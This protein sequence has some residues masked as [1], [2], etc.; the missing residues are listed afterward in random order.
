MSEKCTLIFGGRFQPF[1]LGHVEVIRYLSDNFEGN[2]ILGIVNPDPEQSVPGDDKDWVRFSKEKNPLSYWER[3]NLIYLSLKEFNLLDK[4]EAIVPLPRP[5]INLARAENYLS[6]KPRKFVLCKKWNDEVEIW[7]AEKYIQNGEEVLWVPFDA[8]S[9]LTKLANGELIRSLMTLGNLGWK[10]FFP[11]S[12]KAFIEDNNLVQKIIVNNT[13][14]QAKEY[15]L[16]ALKNE[17]LS[18]YLIEIVT[19]F[20]INFSNSEKIIHTKNPLEAGLRYFSEFGNILDHNGFTIEDLLSYFKQTNS[21]TG[22]SKISEDTHLR[23]S[24]TTKETEIQILRIGDTEYR[25]KYQDIISF[26]VRDTYTSIFFSKPDGKIGESIIQ[27]PL[28]DILS[29]YNQKRFFQTHRSFAI[30][31]LYFDHIQKDE[32]FLKPEYQGKPIR[33]SLAKDRK[34]DFLEL[35]KRDIHL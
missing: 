22:S 31:V 12:A 33:V 14:I 15:I 19:T 17:V 3:Y 4:V 18:N 28:K 6:P 5:S 24:S 21:F 16:T 29:Q 11:T 26:C 20:S 9:P 23:I 13:D 8:F 10:T 34:D 35:L 25:V 2:I 1:H 32:V 27:K 7:K 30:N